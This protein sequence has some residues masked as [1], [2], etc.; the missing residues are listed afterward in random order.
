MPTFDGTEPFW[1]FL[2]RFNN[3]TRYY[4]WSETDQRAHLITSLRGEAAR[5]LTV[6]GANLSVD[7]IM[8]YLRE[9]YAGVAQ[10][11]K[12][13]AEFRILDHTARKMV[14]LYEIWP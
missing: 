1:L 3:C 9:S 12:A 14:S 6:C 5:A 2:L 11:Q 7:Q 13:R 4:Q 10:Q 8:D